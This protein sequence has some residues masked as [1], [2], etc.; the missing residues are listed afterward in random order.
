MSDSHTTAKDQI[1][2]MQ[3]GHVSEELARWCF[4]I[5]YGVSK[6]VTKM[7]LSKS[8]KVRALRLSAIMILNLTAEDR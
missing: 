5:S 2:L 3:D 8:D 1:D 6:A 4:K 7:P